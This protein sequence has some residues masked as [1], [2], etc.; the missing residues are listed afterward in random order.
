MKFLDQY[1]VRFAFF[2][3]FSSCGFGDCCLFWQLKSLDGTLE[4]DISH[5]RFSRN[6]SLCW[7][8][9]LML[10]MRVCMCVCSDGQI[11]VSDCHDCNAPPTATQTTTAATTATTEQQQQQR[12]RPQPAF[13][14]QPDAFRSATSSRAEPCAPFRRGY[15][16]VCVQLLCVC[17]GVI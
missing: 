5:L 10:M 7:A 15:D 12:R 16:V 4:F 11:I 13:Q 3:V 14:T 9:V 2:S 8:D 1:Q 6:R 17:V